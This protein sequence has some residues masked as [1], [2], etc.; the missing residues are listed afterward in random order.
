[1][2]D[3]WISLVTYN[4]AENLPL[5]LSRILEAAPGAHVVIV[6]DSSPDG[7][8]QLIDEWATRYSN[9]HAIHRKGKLGYASAQ[10]EAFTFA[11]SHGAQTF[12]TM[13]ADLSHDPRVIPRLVEAL[14]DADMVIGSRYVLEGSTPG[15]PWRRRLLS[16]YGNLA[17]RWIGGL[18]A[19]DSTSGYRAYRVRAMG[20][21]L[22]D[23]DA[24]GYTFL[25]L[26]LLRSQRTGLRIVEL[27]IVFAD[28]QHGAS[29]MSAS[30]FIEQ[31]R[32]LI[33]LFLARFRKRT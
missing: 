13:D 7:T 16:R 33:R 26:T 1:M 5:I 4:E 28:R 18:R 11:E 2:D 32:L 8:G 23:T 19:R 25:P 6:D 10:V 29:K 20:T 31:L 14:A 30:I 21:V 3:V 17:F 15:W 22:I 24:K 27:P 12:I 9:I